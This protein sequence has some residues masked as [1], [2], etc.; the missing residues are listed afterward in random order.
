MTISTTIAQDKTEETLL[1]KE[2]N[3][4]SND[5]TQSKA[6]HLGPTIKTVEI[7]APIS[8]EK[9]HKND[10]NH[11][12]NA[13]EIRPL[14]A[15]TNEFITLIKEST[16]ANNKGAVILLADWQQ[17]AMTPKGINYLK[18]KMPDKGWTTISIQPPAKPKGYP[19]TA[20]TL[21]LR[22][23][24]NKIALTNYQLKLS[25]I[26]KAVMA[27]ARDYSSVFIVIAEGSHAAILTNLYQQNK[28]TPPNALILLSSYMPS[29][30]ANK[31]FATALAQTSFPVLDLYLTRDHPLAKS[32]AKQRLSAAK[33]EIKAHYRQRQLTN[34]TS[35]YYPQKELLIT[36][37]SWIAAIGW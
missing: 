23:E 4:Q 12:L 30:A 3:A 5:N 18:N 15:G 6:N 34:L 11:Y 33:K 2:K 17:T 29:H 9:I 13:S 26:I 19:S 28:N 27:E 10:I 14:L 1:N 25:V 21:V 36:V 16:T 7:L 8:I 31:Q 20:L 22:K 32:N 37:K 24:E 35:S